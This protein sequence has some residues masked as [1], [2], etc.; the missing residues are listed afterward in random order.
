ME[1]G[2]PYRTNEHY[3][4][5]IP[6]LS[7]PSAQ[8]ERRGEEKE[9]RLIFSPIISYSLHH[10][11]TLFLPL[12]LSSL[13]SAY[14]T[15]SRHRTVLSRSDALDL[16]L[17]YARFES[18]PRYQIS[19]LRSI[20]FF[21]HPQANSGIVTRLGHDHF[22]P[23]P[24]LFINYTTTLHYIV[25]ILSAALNNPLKKTHVTT[26]PRFRLGLHSSLFLISM[27]SRLVYP[28]FSIMHSWR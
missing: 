11:S 5:V 28:C 23:N 26:L 24:F 8:T 9:T 13:A 27:S 6:A 2:E 20:V 3:T 25:P 14:S 10:L 19:W 15:K 21:Q 7:P 4:S 17:G 18:G 16:Y 12:L 22:L 1:R